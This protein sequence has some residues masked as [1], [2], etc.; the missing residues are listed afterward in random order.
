MSSDRRTYLTISELI[1]T[2]GGSIK[3]GPFGTALKASEYVTQGVPLI[4]VREIG[5]GDFHVDHKT[6]CIG[7]TTLK[8]LPEYVLQ[9]GDIVFARKGGIERCALVREKQVGWFLGSDGIRLRPPSTCDARFLAYSLQTQATKDWL[10]QHSTGST[11]ASLNGATIGR[12]PIVLPSLSE[13]NLVADL[14]E[15]FDDRITLL[16]ETNATL[17]AIAQALFKSW[18]V[19]FDPVRAKME[20]RTPEG[21]NE[22]TTA[23][24]PDGFE[25]S[26]LGEVPRGWRKSTLGELIELTK[27]CSY[28]GDGLSEAEGAYM[29][30]LG[31]FNAHRVFASEKI[32]RYTGE[33]KPR[34][35]VQAGDLI[36]ANTDMTQARDI[37]GRPAFV[38]I[39]FDPGFI[40]HHVYKVTVRPEWQK[41]ARAIR[42]LLFFALQESA[43]RERAIGF[44]TGTT[45][46]ALPATAVLGSPALISTA[47]LLDVFD[48]AV[49]PIFEAISTNEQSVTTLAE[50]R[51]TLLPHLI[52]GQLRLPEA[53]A[54]TEAALAGPLQA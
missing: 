23:L 1:S 29:F 50:T 48:G 35:S 51:D 34:H 2:H 42:S 49:Q 18:F 40:S 28:K 44:A 24:F 13:Q 45:V 31:C 27:G 10:L 37:L 25:T 21:M 22:A 41:K 20:G 3:T 52:S 7:P 47:D 17:E 9:K 19:D 43:F 32:K 54:A 15:A 8:R 6:P 5:H 14:L 26:E 33:Y 11:M 16:R 36:I 4:S 12:L 46:L 38:P 39:G 53:Q 30:N